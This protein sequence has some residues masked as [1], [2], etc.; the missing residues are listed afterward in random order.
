MCV[1]KKTFR[2]SLYIPVVFGMGAETVVGGVNVSVFSVGQP[3]VALLSVYVGRL[4][5]SVDAVSR[6]R[7]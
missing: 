4:G 1:L 7:L 5:L 2:C 3:V 6:G